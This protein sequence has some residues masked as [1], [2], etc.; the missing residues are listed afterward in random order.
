MEYVFK[1]ENGY[2]PRCEAFGRIWYIADRYIGG[3]RYEHCLM[4]KSTEKSKRMLFPDKKA[5]VNY[6]CNA[7]TQDD[8]GANLLLQ[9]MIQCRTGNGSLL[10]E[11]DGQR[12]VWKAEEKMLYW[13]EEPKRHTGYMTYNECLQMAKGILVAKERESNG[14]QLSLFN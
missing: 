13:V 10:L 7:D 2:A 6:L 14:M 1:S 4:S 11:K 9:F 12:Y 5:M 8:I 3:D